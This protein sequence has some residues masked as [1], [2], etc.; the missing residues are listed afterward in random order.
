MARVASTLAFAALAVAAPLDARHGSGHTQLLAPDGPTE[1]QI[2]YGPRPYYI[3]QNM[4]EGPLKDKLMSCE[5]GPFSVS[6]WSIGHRGGGTLQIPEESAQSEEAGARMG[7]GVLECDVAFTNDLQ[8]V[9][10]HSLCDLHTT[11]DILLRPELAA[12]CTTP[13]TP[14][15]ETSDAT[16]LCCTSDITHDEF[17]SL[18][19]KMDGSNSSATTPEDYQHGVASFRTELYDTCATPLSLDTFIDLVDALPGYRN[20]TPELKT[21]PADVPMP[22]NGYTQEQYARDVIN[23]FINKGIAAE[24][25]WPQSFLPADIFQWIKEFPEFGAQ[26]VYLDEEGETPETF[27]TAV[28]RLPSLKAQGVNIIAPPFNYLLTYGDENNDTIVPSSYAT[29]AKAA[30]LDIITWSFERSG[31]LDRVEA[32]EDYYYNTFAQ[33]VSYDGQLYEVLDI[34]ANEV[35]VVAM[36]S[37]W[38]ATVGYFANCFGLTGPVGGSYLNK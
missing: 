37:D 10:R 33:A 35:G 14:A 7:A 29:T 12:K 38:S 31:P 34:L 13:F 2:S 19:S 26:A 32:T 8:L 25:V 36:F 18:C 27:E 24:R 6:G 9:C 21:P 5:N 28:A 15:N 30:G 23:A 16:A 20:F 17:M 1:Y 11:T 3:V 22:F 4:T